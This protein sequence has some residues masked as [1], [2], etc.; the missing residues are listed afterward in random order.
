MKLCKQTMINSYTNISFSPEKRG[1]QDFNYYTELLESDLKELGEN[2]GNYKEKFIDKVMTIYHRQSRCASPMITG[3]AK[4]PFSSNMKKINSH[5]KA[6][7]DFTHWRTK[8]F[9]AVNRE[10]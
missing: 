2:Q 6:Y 7:D 10:R 5:H 8:Y 4:F 9:K 3:P 1:E